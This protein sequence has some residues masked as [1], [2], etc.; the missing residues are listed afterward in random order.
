MAAVVVCVGLTTLDVVQ[1]VDTLPVANTKQV[2]TEFRVDL[3]GCAGN[4]AR[5]ALA[6]GCEVR[7]VTAMGAS[8]LAGV[9]RSHLAGVEII[10]VAPPDYPLAVSSV[11]VT[12]DGERA[13]VSHNTTALLTARDVGRDVLRGADVVLHDGHLLPVSV[14]L[15]QAP[16]ELTE[17]APLQLLDGGSWKVGLDDLLPHLDIA[18][19]SAD[20]ALPNRQAT[21]SVRDLAACGIATL[22]RTRGGD[23]VQTLIAG[24][25]GEIPVPQVAAVDTLAAGDV[26]HGALA[27]YLALG[28]AFEHALRKAIAVASRSVTGPGAMAWLASRTN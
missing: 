16:A 14:P 23:S 22:A 10:D 4:A 28:D 3:G 2:A 21:Q 18:V 25:A 5:V 11:L 19:V 8:E 6:L 24:E 27:A 7:L 9:V 12:P 15:A 1:W 17:S 13:V 26:L 20:F